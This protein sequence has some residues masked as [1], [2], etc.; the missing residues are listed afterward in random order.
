MPGNGLFMG[1]S[2]PRPRGLSRQLVW[3]IS[4]GFESILVVFRRYAIEQRRDSTLFTPLDLTGGRDGRPKEDLLDE[5]PLYWRGRPRFANRDVFG[6]R[7]N[8]QNRRSRFR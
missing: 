7:G 5:R 8:W 4:V 6:R 3:L 2:Y 1:K